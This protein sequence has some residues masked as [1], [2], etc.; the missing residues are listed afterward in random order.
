[1][2]IKGVVAPTFTGETSESDNAMYRLLIGPIG[3]Y[4][5]GKTEP[6]FAFM[7][8]LG[9]AVISMVAGTVCDVSVLW[10]NDYSVRI[11][12]P[13][14]K[15]T[16]GGAYIL[17]EHEHVLNPSVKVGDKV[18]AGQKIAI[19]SDYNQHWKAKGLGMIET[20]VVL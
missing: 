19:A 14:M 5:R 4:A 17:Y 1:M 10:S 11:A 13:G 18:T 9:T 15:C 3:E 20:G 8:P 6:Q 12:P 2:Q 16:Q 7:V